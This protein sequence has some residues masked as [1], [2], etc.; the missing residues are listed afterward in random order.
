MKYIF[1]SIILFLSSF[2]VLA[3]EDTVTISGF[4]YIIKKVE[5]N[6]NELGEKVTYIHFKSLHQKAEKNT[7]KEHCLYDGIGDCNS[8]SI[9]LGGYKISD[10]SVTF[11]SFWCHTGD[12]PVSPWGARKQVFSPNRSGKL[13]MV[14]SELY[15]EAG[16]PGWPET[17]GVEF[18]HEPVQTK[19]DREDFH[20]YIL[21]MEKKYQA[22]FV[23]GK[24]ADSLL[25]ETRAFLKSE[26]SRNTKHWKP[27]GPFGTK[28]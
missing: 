3:V 5:E 13:E 2:E 24:R 10:S 19:A 7:L 1:L 26:I 15:L 9:E 21:L 12:A 28:L 4:S 11:Y 25:K 14:Y 20:N 6:G 8:E 27:N 17:K 16:N 23:Y 22:D 18:L